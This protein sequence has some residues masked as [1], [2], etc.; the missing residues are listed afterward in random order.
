M[1]VVKPFIALLF[2]A[3]TSACDQPGQKSSVRPDC[4]ALG[5]HV[6]GQKIDGFI[7]GEEGT[8]GHISACPHIDMR[9][10]FISDP[11]AAYLALKKR[12]DRTTSIVGFK[13]LGDGYVVRDTATKYFFMVVSLDKVIEDEEMTKFANE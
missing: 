4:L 3:L 5:E 8:R 2:A 6:R 7:F 11:P 1:S 9:I 13:A 10:V 12:A